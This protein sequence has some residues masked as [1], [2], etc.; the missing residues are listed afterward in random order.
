MIYFKNRNGFT[1]IEVMITLGI[2]GLVL[3]P[4]FV[5]QS[6]TM[7]VMGQ[8]SQQLVRVL[9]GQVFFGQMQMQRAINPDIEKETKK[10]DDPES[11]FEYS[12]ADIDQKSTLAN[13]KDV[14]LQEV[15]IKWHSLWGPEEDTLVSFVYDPEEQEK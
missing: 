1:L 4:V 5:L 6:T 2:I 15:V 14:G 9:A 7:R 8:Y 11:T 3:T 12:F 10:I 13:F